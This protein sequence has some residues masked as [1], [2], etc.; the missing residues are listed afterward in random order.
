MQAVILAA[1]ESSRFWPLNSKHK[2]QIKLLGRS[3]A[4]WTIKSLTECGI[5][6]IVIVQSPNSPLN[7]EL[8]DGKEMDCKISY[9]VQEKPL[10]TGNAVFLAK[11]FIKEP[12]FVLHPYKFYIKDI[13]QQILKKEKET[14]SPIIF[15]ATPTERPQ[16]YGILEFNGDKVAKICENPLPG[17][18]PSNFRTIAIYFLRPDFFRYYE[19]IEKHHEEDL[20]DAFNFI[21][22]EHGA[23]AVFLEK[24]SPTLK[25][26]WNLFGL[27]QLLF[28]SENFEA[29]VSKSAKIG[30]NIVLKG[31]VF[32]GENVEIGENTV[33]NGPC[34]IGDNCKIGASNVFRG[35]VN[36]EQGVRTGAFMEIKNSIVQE[37]THFHSGYVGDSIIGEDCRIG[38]GVITANRRTDRGEISA[39]VKNNKMNTKRTFLG[40]IVGN[41][42]SF[43][44]KVGTMPGVLIGS[45][46]SVG[47]NS[48]VMKNI[49]SDSIFYNKTEE[50][51]KKRE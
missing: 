3:L 20:I 9:V 34:F 44:I 36:L 42:T 32:I 29:R 37:G 28:E 19:K 48:I 40:L 50:V 33:I 15:V 24:E 38:A 25:Y 6:D 22:K 1:G 23:Q 16:D 43:G 27:S 14:G 11:D 31:Q 7:N 10:G 30:K 46:S 39:V 12:F 17:E 5:S 41:K 51:I 4:Y 13:F 49:P 26:P 35:L 8:G 47:P 21:I 18:E 2:S 45:N